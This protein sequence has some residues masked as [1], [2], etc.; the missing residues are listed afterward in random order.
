MGGSWVVVIGLV[1]RATIIIKR[2]RGL[3]TALITT[4]EPPSVT[5][6]RGRV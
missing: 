5:M 4:R 1:I 2:I 3:M 6:L